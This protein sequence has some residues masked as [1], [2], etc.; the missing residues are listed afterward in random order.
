[1]TFDSD[2]FQCSLSAN[3]LFQSKSRPELSSRSVTPVALSKNEI[4]NDIY[5]TNINSFQ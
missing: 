3:D 1:M 2:T 5:L 4:E